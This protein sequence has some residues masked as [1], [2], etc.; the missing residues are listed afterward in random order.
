MRYSV[1]VVFSV[2]FF[3]SGCTSLQPVELGSI[4]LQ[5]KIVKEDLVAV[6]D[7]IKVVLDS[8]ERKSFKVAEVTPTHI[9]GADDSVS[10]DSIAALESR[11]FSGGKT[12]LLVGSAY[13][14]CGIMAAIG[15]SIMIGF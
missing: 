9:Y 12:A 6:G 7:R 4:E 15:A 2:L 8:G 5:E 11:E 1:V 3:L 14:I 10:I 13:L